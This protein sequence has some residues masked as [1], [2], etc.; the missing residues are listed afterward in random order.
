[1]NFDREATQGLSGWRLR[2]HE[3]IFEADT[4]AGK[5]FDVGLFLAIGISIA[6]VMLES[7]ESISGNPRFA[8]WL[9]GVEW[10]LT[11]LFT[12]E[13]VLRLMCVARPLHYALSFY[14]IVDLLAILPGLLS[15]WTLSES[16]RASSLMAIRGLRLLR[17]F[18]VLKLAQYL[19]EART[20]LVSLKR[21]RAKIVVFFSFVMIVVLLMGSAMYFIEGPTGNGTPRAGAINSIPEGIYWAIVTVTTV[22]YGDIVPQ[23]AGG[24][25]LAALAML[26]G[27]SII[28]VPTGIVTAEVIAASHGGISTQAC[29]GCSREGHDGDAQYCKYCGTRL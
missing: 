26:V 9:R 1:M 6:A 4:P 8:G 27:Y 25:A 17:V 3:I 29:P 14:G 15:V 22:G 16:S 2:L 20:L 13:Y 5:T 23:S 24:K 7:I 11:L 10:G 19:T 28:V 18:R 21:T 12:V